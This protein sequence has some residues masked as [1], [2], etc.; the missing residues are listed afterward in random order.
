M[1][2]LLWPSAPPLGSRSPIGVGDRLR[3]NDG[4][5]SGMTLEIGAGMTGVLA[6]KGRTTP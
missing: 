6:A 2:G 5:G 3:G 1:S 4:M